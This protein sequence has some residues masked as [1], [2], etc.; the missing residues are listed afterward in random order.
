M[1]FGQAV[2]TCFQKYVDFSGRARRSEFWWWQLF[3]IV[4]LGIAL[5]ATGG[6]LVAKFAPANTGGHA[7]KSAAAPAVKP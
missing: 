2:G 1:G 4:V 7:A 3:S 6:F 5:A